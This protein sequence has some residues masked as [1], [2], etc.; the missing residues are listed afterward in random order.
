MAGEAASV[1]G[2]S[3]AV[4]AER[5]DDAACSVA[6]EV[7]VG[8]PFVAADLAAFAERCDVVTF[9]HEQVDLDALAALATEGAVFRPGPDVLELAVDKAHMRRVLDGAGVPV[10]SFLVVDDGPDAVE[11]FNTWMLS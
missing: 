3:M 10:P 11:T 5:P 4:L 6:A 2:L 1:L 7:M 9:D 8:S